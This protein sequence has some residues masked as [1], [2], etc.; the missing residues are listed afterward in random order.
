MFIKNNSGNE[1]KN[2]NCGRGI[3]VD[4]AP[5]STF[6]MPDEES[7]RQLL[8]LLGAPDWLVMVQEPVEATKLV[9]DVVEPIVE[10]IIEPIVEPAPK[11]K[12]KKIK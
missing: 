7:A 10:P 5:F 3:Y 12:S 1:W 2:Y 8:A 4:I 6:E 11:K 9:E